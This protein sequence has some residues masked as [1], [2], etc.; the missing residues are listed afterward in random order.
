MS[1]S[2]SSFHAWPILVG[3]FL[4]FL[5]SLEQSLWVVFLT[6]E[7]DAASIVNK[8]PREKTARSVLASRGQCC[9]YSLL[10]LSLRGCSKTGFSNST[11]HIH[12]ISFTKP[13]IWNKT[14]QGR[15]TLTLCREQ[16]WDSVGSFLL[17]YH[18]FSDREALP[19]RQR[20]RGRNCGAETNL[21]LTS[22]LV[23]KLCS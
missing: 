19:C 16:I 1:T 23:L 18:S 2:I 11:E 20:D 22:C 5:L 14:W 9:H 13:N 3:V 4:Y 7:A 10:S 12:Q 17:W 21:C 6:D 15:Q 8:I